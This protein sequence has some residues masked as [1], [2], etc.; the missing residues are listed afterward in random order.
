MKK[1]DR[2]IAALAFLGAAIIVVRVIGAVAG[3]DLIDMAVNATR[4]ADA[5]GWPME[6]R[7]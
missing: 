5:G 7:F 6:T 2:I 4:P 3:Y 1:S